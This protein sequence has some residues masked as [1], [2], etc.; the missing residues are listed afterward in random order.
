M[1]TLIQD[2]RY[3]LRVLRNSPGFTLIALITLALGIGANTAI[4]TVMN[5]VLLSPLPY[6]E[7]ERLVQL[8]NPSEGGLVRIGEFSPQ[9]FDDLARESKSYSAIAS[10]EFLPGQTG[11]NLTSEGDPVRLSVAYVS[12]QFFEVFPVRP[13]AGRL[14]LRDDDVVGSNRQVVISQNLWRKQFGGDTGIAGRKVIIDGKPFTVVGVAPQRMHFPSDEVD[15]WAPITLLDDTSVPHIR[16]LRWMNAVARLKPGVSVAEAHAEANVIMARLATQYPDTNEGHDKAAVKN[17][18][19]VIVGNVRPAMLVL[20]ATVALVLLIACANVANLILARGTGRA[21]EM[22]IRAALGADR[23]RIVRQILTESVLLSFIGG[24]LGLAFAAWS[25]DILITMSAGSIPRTDAIALDWRVLL[26]TFLTALTTGVMFGLIPAL[27]GSGVDF[28][29]AMK[30]S[31]Y[32]T[33]ESQSRRRVR[34]AL[35]IGEVAMAAVLLVASTLVVKSLWKLT[36]VD[37]GFEANNVLAIRLV[38]PKQR[39]IDEERSVATSYRLEV[40]RRISEVPEVVSVG[41][42][43]TLPL[44]AGGEPYGFDYA[45]PK[46]KVNI[47]PEAGVFIVSPGY[48]KTLEIPLISGRVF[49]EDDNKPNAPAVLIVNR[50]LAN[51]YWPGEDAIGKTLT[52]G[53]VQASVIGV[54]GDVRS[55][56]LAT[57]PRTAIYGPFGKF[58]RSVMH[59][60]VRT[61]GDP[62]AMAGAVRQAIWGLEKNQPIDMM[63]LASATDKQIAQPRFFTTLLTAFGSLA[64]LLAAIGIYGV[65]SYNVHQQ[66]RDIGIRMA[67]GAQPG[68]VLTMVLK[69]ALRM[70]LIGLGIGSVLALVA[71]RSL[72]SLLFGVSTIDAATYVLMAIVLTGMAMLASYIPARRATKVDPM[73]AL[74]YE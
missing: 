12:G 5:G 54:V 16:Q 8:F 46:G 28:Q 6:P 19:D 22:A 63:T 33:S 3:G 50:A 52:A 60:Y 64:L 26:F 20:F 40:L 57:P 27:R 44:E 14:L 47:K 38:T 48:Y 69:G 23:S 72:K 17:L 35:I 2:I 65:I 59:V 51:R 71:T 61:Q 31:G 70:T 36:H 42:S 9:D 53:K 68:Q 24:G 4:F 45:G 58:P 66:I 34:D 10:Y 30:E 18:R 25:V 7:P 49:N 11:M 41:A 62:L 55:E 67:L 56:G 21:R 1:N 43:K 74:R 32:N 29:L 15:I 13:V 39:N 73:V 37:P